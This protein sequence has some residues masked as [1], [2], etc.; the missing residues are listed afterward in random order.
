MTARAYCVCSLRQAVGWVWSTL[1]Q[2]YF[3]SYV[4]SAV[5][6]MALHHHS[7]EY[8][9]VFF[10]FLLRVFTEDGM[11]WTL[12]QMSVVKIPV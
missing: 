11:C 1:S 8:F 5:G 7:Y 3:M 9:C 10:F 2:I 6:L 4:P 12:F